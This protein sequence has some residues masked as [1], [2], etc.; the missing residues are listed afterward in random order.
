MYPFSL[1]YL[2]S[3]LALH[4]ESPQFTNKNTLN[5]NYRSYYEKFLCHWYSPMSWL[6]KN[7]DEREK[8]FTEFTFLLAQAKKIVRNQNT[9][10]K[11]DKP[12]KFIVFGDL[13]GDIHTFGRSLNELYKEGFIDQTLTLK[14]DC[15]LVLLGNVVTG[16][17]SVELL[18]L[19]FYLIVHNKDNVIYLSGPYER[20]QYWHDFSTVH[21]LKIL[22]D[23]SASLEKELDDLFSQLPHSL[24]LN[25]K[26]AHQDDA[27]F[28]FSYEGFNSFDL[29]VRSQLKTQMCSENPGF[30][31][32]ENEGLDFDLPQQGVSTWRL[33]SCPDKRMQ[34]LYHFFYDSFVVLDAAPDV[35]DWTITLY[36]RDVRKD[37]LFEKKYRNARTGQKITEE[38]KNE[39]LKKRA[40]FLKP[41]KDVSIDHQDELVLGCT[42]DLSSMNA[43]K[44]ERLLKGLM[45]AF[46]KLNI[47]AGG[48]KGKFIRLVAL[49]DKYSDHLTKQCMDDLYQKFK[50][51]VLV[52]CSGTGPL[53]SASDTIKK[54]NFLMLFP[55][56]GASAFRQ[57]DAKNFINFRVSYDME[58]TVLVNHACFNLGIKRFAVLYED[59]D[60]G[61]SLLKGVKEK[62]SAFKV[63]DVLSISYQQNALINRSAVQQL[64]DFH[65]GGMF[66]FIN[67]YQ[68]EALVRSMN[69]DILNG[70]SLFGTSMLPIDVS[71]FLTK[72]GLNLM[73]TEVVPNPAFSKLEIVKD[74]KDILRTYMPEELMTTQSLE[75]YINARILL[76]AIDG[77]SSLTREAINS[78]FEKLSKYKLDG[79]DLTFD[80]KQRQIAYYLWF[81]DGG[82]WKK[83]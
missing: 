52:S 83:V 9:K 28:L 75:A 38:K 64:S 48:I 32:R 58:L 39:L 18:S 5:P 62:L 61:H 43:F 26:D 40:T 68:T 42:L 23:N 25:Y 35:F 74:Y 24:W 78:W 36:S 46:N 8:F 73:K 80:E 71:I 60:F 19:L 12:K 77:A 63:S 3:F 21:E 29:E 41:I 66:F 30:T 55:Y 31:Y 50:T 49:D 79:L 4:K 17:H 54:Y 27:E 16:V 11:I 65:P 6:G 76:A 53:L 2:N 51:N 20:D 45:L 10:I 33:F 69:L 7:T 14:K 22:K 47:E 82:K 57:P 1:N 15:Y 81:N 34:S 37:G 59:S 67:Q 13:L 56:S 70:V 44:G 72:R